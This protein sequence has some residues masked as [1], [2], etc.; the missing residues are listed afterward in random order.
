MHGGTVQADSDGLGKGSRFAVRLPALPSQADRSP[1]IVD[2]AHAQHVARRVL[3]VDD[4]ADNVETLGMVLRAEG[5]EVETAESG[6][7]ALD[8]AGH[9]EPEIVIIDIGMPGMDGYE[10][11]RRLRAERATA[12]ATLIALSGFGQD[13]ARERAWKAGF[14]EYLVKPVDLGEIVSLVDG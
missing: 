11:A 14:D 1:P 10:L 3:V 4:N 8:I 6:P 12:S 2:R 5:H 13:G 9:F 7:R